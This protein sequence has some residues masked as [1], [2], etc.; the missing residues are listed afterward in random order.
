MDERVLALD[1]YLRTR[2]RG[3]SVTTAEVET[4]SEEMRSLRIWPSEVRQNPKFRNADGV[5]LKLANFAGIDPAHAGKGMPN[6]SKG[7]EETWAKWAHRPNELHELALRILEVGTSEDLVEDPD[8]EDDFGADEGDALYRKHR[9]L[10][11]SR[12]LVKKKKKQ[13]LAATGALACEVCGFD[14]KVAYG[15]EWVIDVHHTVPLHVLGKSN[16]RLSDLAL[17]CPTCHR[18]IHAHKPFITPA[19]L[20]LKVQTT[21]D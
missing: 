12:A 2:E 16:T 21:S 7:D 13:V 8:P 18:S 9:R 1:L 5:G 20:R 17:V 11:R 4:L 19:E 14:S 15:I 6:W 3:Y 10:E